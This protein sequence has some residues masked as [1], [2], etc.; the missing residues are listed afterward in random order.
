MICMTVKMV[1]VH[2]KRMT[3]IKRGHI[4]VGDGKCKWGDGGKVGRKGVGE[5]DQK[6]TVDLVCKGEKVVLQAPE[7]GK[8]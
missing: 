8:M 2:G 6:D 5:L 4:G 3:V 1:E 7:D